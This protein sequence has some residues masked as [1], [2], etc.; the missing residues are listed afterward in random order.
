MKRG[1]S[2]DV[3][4]NLTRGG[5]S[6]RYKGRVI[7]HADGLFVVRPIFAVSLAGNQRVRR[8]GKKYVHAY[9]RGENGAVTWP[10]TCGVPEVMSQ[11]Q[12]VVYN[13]YTS[14]VFRLERSGKHVWYAAAAILTSKGVYVLSPNY[15]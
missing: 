4:R 12:K 10:Y 13:P 9:V 3:Y 11:W 6:I 8:E 15:E 2:I 1:A 5:Y 14:T 7:D